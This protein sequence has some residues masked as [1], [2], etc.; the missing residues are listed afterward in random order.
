MKL[1]T[2]PNADLTGFASLLG[3]SFASKIHLLTQI[4]QQHHYPS[5]GRYKEGLLS[6][7]IS[8]YLPK[9]FEVGTGFVLF[10][11]EA[12]EERAKKPGF[13]KLNMGSY[14][15]SKQCDVIIFDSSKIPVAFPRVMG[16]PGV[17]WP[18]SNSSIFA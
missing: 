4:L 5:L 2:R 7:V 18:P 10:V 16:S 6:K 8:E 15:V 14:S 12:T 1:E 17:H 11:H 13:D 9:V 3:D